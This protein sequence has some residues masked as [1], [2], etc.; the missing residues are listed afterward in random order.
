MKEISFSDFKIIPDYDSIHRECIDDKTYFG[1][2]YSK[3]VSNS[4]LKYIDPS[5]GGSPEKF[6]RN[7]HINSEALNL[8]SAIHECILQPNDF[9]L[10][11]KVNRPSAKLGMVM[12]EIYYS[13]KNKRPFDNFDDLVTNA[14]LKVDYYSKS[15]KSK[16][17]LIKDAWSQYSPTLKDAIKDLDE[18]KEVVFLCDKDW[19]VATACINE[20]LGNKY[21]TN[22]LYPT[23]SW[24]ENCES[25]NED[26]LF[27]N[28]IVIY[29]D[30]RC[31]VIPFKL[32]IDNWTID[33]DSQTI[34]LNDLKTTGKSLNV[35][36]ES[37]F[38]NFRYYR[39]L[40][41]YM[42][43]LKAYTN[44]FFG[45]S[46]N[47]GWKFESNI[48]AVETIPKYWSRRF[49]IP[50]EELNR[51]LEEFNMLMKMVGAYEIFGYDAEL[52]FV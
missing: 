21:I 47:T 45:F 29:K 7:P 8:G 19:D 52:T 25:Y 2:K 27:M 18:K 38:N 36:M 49:R 48:C 30:K 26:A 15:I 41:C 39:Q 5:E 16:L 34:T 6:Q 42:N 40:A 43:A 9:Q 33:K 50:Q 28:Y 24:G 46:E 10:C 12:D 3:F 44:K 32:K 35:F 4:R 1:E 11:P 31:A 51:G 13:L 14:A 22:V 37:S 17:G 20:V 23:D